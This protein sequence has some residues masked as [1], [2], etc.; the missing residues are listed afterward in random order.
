MFLG[1][2]LEGPGLSAGLLTFCQGTFTVLCTDPASLGEVAAAVL[3]AA[4]CN[5][6]LHTAAQR[7]VD[8]VQDAGG[9]QDRRTPPGFHRLKAEGDR[10]E[11]KQPGIS[12]SIKPIVLGCLKLRVAS[13]A[14]NIQNQVKE[15]LDL[16]LV[17]GELLGD[18][19]QNERYSCYH[20]S[21]GA[22]I[23]A[24]GGRKLPGVGS[25]AG[26]G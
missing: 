26:T 18:T 8:H 14:V 7:V 16:L 20:L 10:V 2:L 9:V 1:P 11:W 4:N 23:S 13:C 12:G 5:A 15:S 24:K 6:S 22:S 17:Q 25:E 21:W 19:L 3:T